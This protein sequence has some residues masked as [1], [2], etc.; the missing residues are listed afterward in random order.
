MTET[1]VDEQTAVNMS[2]SGNRIAQ[3]VSGIQTPLKNISVI[4]GTKGYIEMPEWWKAQ[5]VIMKSDKRDE[6]FIDER[7]SWGYDFEVREVNKLIKEGKTE[8]SIVSYEK[9]LQLMEI[10][11]VTREKIGLRYP[12]E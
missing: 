10:L 4:Y 1:G 3:A 8:S 11:D 7:E 12:F 6:V 2:F 5:K 9:S